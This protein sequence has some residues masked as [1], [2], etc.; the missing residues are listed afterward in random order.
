MSKDFPTRA[1]LILW[2]RGHFQT[3]KRVMREFLESVKHALEG[4]PEEKP[5]NQNNST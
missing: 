1:E 4:K 3:T 5:N 2:K